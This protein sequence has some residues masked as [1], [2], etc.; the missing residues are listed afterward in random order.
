M[1]ASGGIDNPFKKSA[2]EDGKDTEVI[3]RSK[4]GYIIQHY[5][6][7]PFHLEK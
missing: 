4:N 6:K 5:T 7:I 3:K 1:L 2:R